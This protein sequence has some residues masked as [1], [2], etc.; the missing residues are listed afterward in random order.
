MNEYAYYGLIS[1]CDGVA[2]NLCVVHQACDRCT[3]SS[4]TTGTDHQTWEMDGNGTFSRP[5]SSAKDTDKT[6][7]AFPHRSTSVRRAP[8]PEL[9]PE[10]APSVLV[11]FS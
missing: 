2:T 4:H 3:I 7:H 6:R 1:R 9:A 5:N 11:A 10:L 8:A